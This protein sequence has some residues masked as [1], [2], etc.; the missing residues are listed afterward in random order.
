M[1]NQRAVCERRQLQFPSRCQKKRAKMTQLNPSPSSFM[2][3]DERKASRNRSPPRANAGQATTHALSRRLLGNEAVAR[4]T[5]VS[6]S[7]LHQ[8]GTWD[9]LQGP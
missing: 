2:Q 7:C 5:C 3:Q 8:A 6:W 4:N 1:G 9:V